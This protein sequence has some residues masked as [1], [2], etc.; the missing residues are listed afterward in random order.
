MKR[1]DSPEVETKGIYGELLSQLLL[2]YVVFM[3]D[4]RSRGIP[5]RMK[6]R[7]YPKAPWRI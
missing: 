3:T 2:V 1:R 4:H 5:C 7:K 6:D